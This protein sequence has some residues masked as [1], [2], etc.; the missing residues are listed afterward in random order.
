MRT[1][2]FI[3]LATEIMSAQMFLAAPTTLGCNDPDYDDICTFEDNCTGVFNPDQADFDG[4]GIGDVCDGDIDNDGRANATDC[5]S[6]D[7][8]IQNI[9]SSCDDGD[10]YTHTDIVNGSCVCEGT[11]DPVRYYLNAS[12]KTAWDAAAQGDILEISES[13]YSSMIPG[14]GQA[15]GGSSMLKGTAVNT[16]TENPGFAS[17]TTVGL[18]ARFDLAGGGNY[19]IAFTF[20][21]VNAGGSAELKIAQTLN[22]TD[23]PEAGYVDFYNYDWTIAGSGIRYYVIKHATRVQWDHSWAIWTDNKPA[24]QIWPKCSICE[25]W[26]DS[27]NSGTID[28]RINNALVHFRLYEVTE[29]PY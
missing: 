19:P 6:Y 27:G 21:S 15:V 9:G 3:L 29:Q 25:I 20:W 4:D 12:E 13:S 11:F 23:V 10:Q 5:D 26:F 7:P 16:S 2:L 28:G 22:S 17:S 8:T 18:N 24:Y 1:L 14:V